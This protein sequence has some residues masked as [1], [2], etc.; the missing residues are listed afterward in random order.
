M[1]DDD[2]E[3]RLAGFEKFSEHYVKMSRDFL[4]E[5]GEAAWEREPGS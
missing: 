4:E 1:A 5:K 2:E 3:S